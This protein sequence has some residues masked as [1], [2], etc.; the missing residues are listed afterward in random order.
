MAVTTRKL[1][2]K[3]GDIVEVISGKDKGKRGKVLSTIPKAGKVIVEGVN[4]LT[5]HTKPR[6]VNQPGGIIRQEGPMYA[7]KV[8]L[9]CKKCNKRTR[10]GKKI[11]DDGTKVR[12]CKVCGE[13]FND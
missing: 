3:K 2:V 6:G 8:M 9:V 1:H 12:I 10:V 11:L 4:M 5:K 7:S 13:T